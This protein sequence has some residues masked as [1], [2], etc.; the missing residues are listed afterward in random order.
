MNNLF[1]MPKPLSERTPEE[2]YALG[3]KDGHRKA[4]AWG[5]LSLFAAIVLIKI[6]DK[7]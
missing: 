4:I 7:N 3:I 6:A 5:G 1:S 2:A